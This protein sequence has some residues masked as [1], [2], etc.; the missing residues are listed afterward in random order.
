MILFM[1]R[2]SCLSYEASFKLI[3]PKIQKGKGF[4]NLVLLNMQHFMPPLKPM[5]CFM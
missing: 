3:A 1:D 5:T 2:Q 4:R